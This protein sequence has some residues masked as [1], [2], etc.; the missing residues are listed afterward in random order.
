MFAIGAIYRCGYRPRL[1]DPASYP[2]SLG[3][4]APLGYPARAGYPA[5]GNPMRPGI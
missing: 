4:P 5:P 1:S 2:A 3:Y